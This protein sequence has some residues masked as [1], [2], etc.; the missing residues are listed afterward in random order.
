MFKKITIAAVAVLLV[1]GL[2]FGRNLVP[3]ATT[4]YKNVKQSVNDSVPIE[5]QIDVARDQ[6]KRIGPEVKQMRYEI[7][8]ETVAVKRLEEQLV[9]QKA[10]HDKQYAKIM[11]FKDHL[12]A[13]DSHYVSHG[14]AYNNDHVR[15]N[16]ESLFKNY[17]TSEKT[18]EK[19]EKIVELRKQ[20]LD[21][22][23]MKLDESIAQAR[24]LEVQ[25]ENLAA[26]QQM[27]EVAKTA[28][29]FTFDDSELSRTREMIDQIDAR[30]DV[31]TQLMNMTPDYTGTIPV[32]D[33]NTVTSGNIVEE[34]NSYFQKVESDDVASK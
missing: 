12:E 7:A 5:T 33:D 22:A 4:V 17:R 18:M 30:I 25:I 20:A 2:L 11:T 1:G 21:S 13:G 15:S 24:E 26:R 29:K 19:L 16:L 34:I 28:N 31:E 9:A 32:E 8:K 3:Y 6:L 10:S 23:K 27:V 14:K